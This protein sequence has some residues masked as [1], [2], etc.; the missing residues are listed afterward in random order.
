MREL[1]RALEAGL[2]G[3]KYVSQGQEGSAASAFW[4]DRQLLEICPASNS[5]LSCGEYAWPSAESQPGTDARCV[6]HLDSCSPRGEHEGSHVVFEVFPSAKPLKP[7]GQ[8]SFESSER[9]KMLQI[10]CIGAGSQW[11]RIVLG[12]M[13]V[14]GYS[15]FARSGLGLLLL[16]NSGTTSWLGYLRLS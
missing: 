16:Q 13:R 5:V 2:C 8:L 9:R 6:P 12:T 11:T 14:Q 4:E 1:S 3:A 10:P 15:R 7:G